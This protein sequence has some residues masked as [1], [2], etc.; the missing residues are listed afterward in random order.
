MYEDEPS[1]KQ[2]QPSPSNALR[3]VRIALD[4][5]AIGIEFDIQ[6]PEQS[7]AIECHS[8]HKYKEQCAG[9][10]AV[11]SEGIGRIE[12]TKY[13]CGRQEECLSPAS[14]PDCSPSVHFLDLQRVE[15]INL[16]VNRALRRLTVLWCG[17]ELL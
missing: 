12:R 4:R 2:S 3:D 13:V 7:T 1:H 6:P 10:I 8:S 16:Y 11:L 17:G 9:N 15:A 5:K 14:L